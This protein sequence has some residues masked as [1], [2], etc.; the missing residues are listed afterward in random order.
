MDVEVSITAEED[1]LLAA[2]GEDS[3]EAYFP[4]SPTRFINLASGDEFQVILD[5]E[6]SVEALEVRGGLRAQRV[7]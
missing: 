1:H 3:P 4:L 5:E 7:R 2:V 6:G